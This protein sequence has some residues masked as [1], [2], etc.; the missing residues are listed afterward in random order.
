M[1]PLVPRLPVRASAHP[2]ADEVAIATA[3]VV[4]PALVARLHARSVLQIDCGS[5]AWLGAARNAG[6][7]DV[8][9]VE[10]HATPAEIRRIGRDS[11][12][13]H[14][15]DA[16]FDLRRRFDLVLAP[17]LAAHPPDAAGGIA[18]ALAR[19]GDVIL[20]GL[21]APADPGDRIWQHALRALGYEPVD[22]LPAGFAADAT[23]APWH[24][25]GLL[26]V[27]TSTARATHGLDLVSERDHVP[28]TDDESHWRPPAITASE[29]GPSPRVAVVI[30]VHDYAHFL[31]DAVASV[32]AQ[33]WPAVE[34]V[35]VDD[36]STDDTAAVASELI[37]RHKSL[38]LR[39]V[40]QPNQGVAQARNHGVR[41]TT[42]PLV[43]QLDADDR[44]EPDAIARLV[45]AL[46]A[47]PTADIAHCDAREFG[48]GD[49][50][51]AAVPR[52]SLARLR[53]GNCL[54]YCALLRRDLFLR[55]GGYRDI[56]GGYDDWDL[57]LSAAE[58]GA[59]FT[60][61]AAPLLRYRRHGMSLMDRE[62]ARGH[63]LRAQVVFNHPRTFAR[64]ELRLA[65]DVLAQ[66]ASARDPDLG[67][68]LRLAFDAL[69]AKRVR[70][71][72]RHLAGV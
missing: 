56:R 39:F 5:A 41:H 66:D 9:G 16:D 14:A 44:L 2:A 63:V 32:A 18:A 49:A 68:R 29:L 50:R 37:A 12:Q 64:R 42:A 24:R 11:I 59:R 65:A 33:T 4:L 28:T 27:A 23:I 69:L 31:P 40:Q 54:N 10:A 43:M 46:R 60:H 70:R 30:P 55:L 13:H 36:G 48:E 61:V 34:C 25:R 71:A 35:I 7:T 15:L 21:A 20:L 38:R 1:R 8:V 45:A 67:L 52:V 47:D 17:D 51:L 72:W 53:R 22:A 6:A 3:A 26:V 62:R 58:A 57:W 19:H